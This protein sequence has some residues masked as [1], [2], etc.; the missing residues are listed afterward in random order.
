M[1]DRHLRALHC[2]V[3]KA[4]MIFIE[5]GSLPMPVGATA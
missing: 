4:F 1:P 3:G 2:L 5:V